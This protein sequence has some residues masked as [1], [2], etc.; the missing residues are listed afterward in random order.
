MIFA[1]PTKHKRGG[2]LNGR[3]KLITQPL[4]L[5][6]SHRVWGEIPKERNLWKDKS[7]YRENPQEVV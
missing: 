4:G 3:K 1:N 2:H 5:Q 6:I 7:G